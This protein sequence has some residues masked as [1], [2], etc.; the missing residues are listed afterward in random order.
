MLHDLFTQS[1]KHR[2]SG[3]DEIMIGADALEARRASEWLE[4]ACRRGGVPRTEFERLALCLEEVLANI[5]Q[6][7]GETALSEPI[8]VA[9]EVAPVE[10]DNAA[11]VTVWDAGKAFDP[12]SAPEARAPTTLEEALPHGMGLGLIRQCSSSLHY[13]REAGRNQLTFGTRWSQG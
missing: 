13:R 10:G 2:L 4:A 12:S 8:R 1:T 3:P 7:G 9:F 6:H 11:R 5:I